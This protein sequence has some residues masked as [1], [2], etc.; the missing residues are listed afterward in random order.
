MKILK[1]NIGLI[2]LI[3]WLSLLTHNITLCTQL[4]LKNNSGWRIEIIAPIKKVIEAGDLYLFGSIPNSFNFIP[5]RIVW[6]WF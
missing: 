6:G 3:C 4:L 2:S 5:Y 1:S